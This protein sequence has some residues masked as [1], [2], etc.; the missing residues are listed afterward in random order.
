MIAITCRLVF[1]T[2][3]GATATGGAE[4]TATGAG[5]GAIAFFLALP[6]ISWIRFKTRGESKRRVIPLSGPRVASSVSSTRWRS[7]FCGACDAPD[8]EVSLVVWSLKRTE[9]PG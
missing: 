2:T 3:G 4:T 8:A 5:G 7:F 9:R 6:S 1:R